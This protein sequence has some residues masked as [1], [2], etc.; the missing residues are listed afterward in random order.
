MTRIPIILVVI[1]ILVSF[2][3]FTY[4]YNV[5]DVRIEAEIRQA[6]N[7]KVP[8]SDLQSHID[9]ILS[10]RR[11]AGAI[12]LGAIGGSVLIIIIMVLKA[13]LILEAMV[14]ARTRDLEQ[15]NRDL[16]VKNERLKIN[17]KAQKEF[18][19]IAAH[20][21][22][23]PIQPIMGIADLLS[24][25]LVHSYQRSDGN[26][27]EIAEISKEEIMM[28]ARNARRLDNLASDLLMAAKM[29]S[30]STPLDFER[31][32]LV[33]LIGDA[34]KETQRV[35]EEAGDS[36]KILF[37]RCGLYESVWV[38]A[39]NLKIGR[40]LRNLLSNAVKFGK[41]GLLVVSI[42]VTGARKDE[43][44]HNV[45]VSIR[46]NGCGIDDL[47][48][49]RLFS[50]FSSTTNGDKGGTGLGLFI[51]KKIIDAHGGRIWAENNKDT[52][53]AEFNF[54]LPLTAS[55]QQHIGDSPDCTVESI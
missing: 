32:D 9:G 6:F 10:D 17:D 16:A 43:T 46:D 51:A 28:V 5:V 20:E 26:A 39:D 41:D 34:I 18:L 54:S 27:S 15:L 1:I 42:Q 13:K 2:L 33:K 4:M 29:E 19:N 22:R 11:M 21:L 36:T 37:E 23:T 30:L 25:Q 8:L 12:L 7:Q 3:A 31:V 50:K 45:T 49:P 47:I 40:V 38:D 48:M 14:N 35:I 44:G 52:N 24:S 53:G 55:L